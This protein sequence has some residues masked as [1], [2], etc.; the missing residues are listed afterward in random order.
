VITVDYEYGWTQE[1]WHE[2]E[3]TGTIP[4]LEYDQT[5]YKFL[6]PPADVAKSICTIKIILEVVDGHIDAEAIGTGADLMR[7]YRLS[8]IV[9]DGKATV[10]ANSVKITN[11]AL[12]DDAK[13][14]KVAAA[15]GTAL[16]VDYDWI[17]ETPE[18]YQF[19]AVFAE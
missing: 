16:T 4:A 12:S 3:A 10:Y 8:H 11:W 13:S 5:E 19:I 9:K 18:V 1:I 7:T 6:L 17:S 15:A 2:M 14:I